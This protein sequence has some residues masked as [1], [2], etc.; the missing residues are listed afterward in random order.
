MPVHTDD[1]FELD[2][3]NFYLCHA[4]AD[5]DFETDYS[6]GDDYVGPMVRSCELYAI[7]L[8]GL[9]LTRTQAV[10][11]TSEATIAAHEDDAAAKILESIRV[12][13]LALSGWAAE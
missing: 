9:T 8:G 10:D 13:D 6:H 5:F 3:D 1:D 12:G 11:M 2:G 4:S 7:R